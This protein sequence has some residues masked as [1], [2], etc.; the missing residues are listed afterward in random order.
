MDY[1]GDLY[2]QEIGVEFVAK[3]RDQETFPDLET[4]IAQIGRDVEHARLELA[5]DQGAAIA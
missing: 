5:R 2:G 4:L 1:D 3:L